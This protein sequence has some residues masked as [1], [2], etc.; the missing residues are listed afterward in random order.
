MVIVVVCI[1]ILCL[2]ALV[3]AHVILM[4]A[5]RIEGEIDSLFALLTQIVIILILV[6][7][8]AVALILLGAALNYLIQYFT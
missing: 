6:I 8:G 1:L 4:L 7:C 5:A 2:S 3:T